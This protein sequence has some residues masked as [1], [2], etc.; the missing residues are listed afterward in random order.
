MNGTL[1]KKCWFILFLIVLVLSACTQETSEEDTSTYTPECT[2]QELIDA[3]DGANNDGQPSEIILPPNCTYTLTQVE[4]SFPWNNMIINNG[5]PAIVSEITIRGQNSTIE[6]Q[7][8]P[9]SDPFGHFY[10]DVESK[11]KL[12]DLTLSGGARNAGGAILSNHG[13][14]LVFNVNFL[15]NRAIQP[16]NDTVANGGAIYGYFSNVRILSNSL[17]QGNLAGV[18]VPVGDNLGGAVYAINSSLLINDSTFMENYVAGHGGAVFSEKTP[19]STGGGLVTI[20]NGTFHDNHAL[21][22]GG[23][24]ALMNEKEGVF[25][26]S[27]DFI[28]NLAEEDGG[29]IFSQ[30]SDIDSSHTYFQ[31]NMAQNGA[32]VYTRRSAEGEMSEYAADSSTF[33][34]N[35]ADQSAGGLFSEN[36][37]VETSRTVFIYNTADRCGALQLGG[38]PGLD[39]AAG[40]LET[41]PRINSRSEL[42]LG[43]AA[44]NEAYVGF[45]GGACHMMGELI[46]DDFNFN[47][48]ETPSYGGGLL[49]MDVLEATGSD[50]TDNIA[51]RGGALAVG[52]PVDDNNPRSPAF[53]SFY[54]RLTGV[55]IRD[56]NASNQGGGIWAHSGGSLQIVK[57]AI[58]WNFADQEGGGVYLDEGNLYLDNSTL[59]RN[60]A[61]RGGGL[62]NVGDNSSLRLMHTTVAYNEATDTGTELR[63]KGGGVNINGVVYMREAMIVLNTSN[64]CDLN[65]GLR[66]GGDYETCDDYYCA[67][68]GSVDSDD[69]CGFGRTEP[70]PQIGS[71]NNEYV[72]I[73]A[74][75]P[76]IDSAYTCYL[77]DDQLGTSRYQGNQCEPGSIEYLA[78]TPPPPPPPP[79]QPGEDPGDCDPFAGLEPSIQMLNIDPRD[80]VLPVYLRFASAAP[81]IGDDGSIPYLATLGGLEAYLVNQQ[82]FEDRVYFM[83]EI[84]PSMPGTLQQLEVFK[85]GCDDPVFTEP[86]LSIPLIGCKEDLNEETCPLAGGVWFTGVDD[87]Y[88]VC[89]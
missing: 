61:F 33:V 56:N 50:F 10:L 80:L 21:F 83:F 75:S 28:G 26:V 17:F 57:S 19:T 77:T 11:L 54:S 73:L 15:N 89:P 79:P 37:D 62:Y 30:D 13:D 58:G 35:F 84:G 39:V 60:V 86:Q 82:G 65:Q 3:I 5:L 4:N 31:N 43:N 34:A 41:A 48:N 76:L 70:S 64:D 44:N 49:S 74:G 12:Y 8:A 85:E 81:G 7:P 67:Q 29:A 78:T 59:A 45:G 32:G 25:I 9:G 20:Q 87:P 52:F 2:V 55:M 51:F 42:E 66:V 63:S 1:I 38:Y 71:F 24:L 88:C 27:S 40:D 22:D 14:L 47:G 23:A 18:P 53:L 6:C 46:L 69:S 72:P 68:I 16:T 36:S